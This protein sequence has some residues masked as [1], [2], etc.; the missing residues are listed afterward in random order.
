LLA[1]ETDPGCY[2]EPVRWLPELVRWACGKTGNFILDRPA[3]PPYLHLGWDQLLEVK[4]AWLRARPLLAQRDRL[5]R[6]YEQDP[7]RLTLLADVLM[8]G[9]NHDYLDW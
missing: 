8:D 2:P 6:W 9:K 3:S 7:A 4:T 1:I 5:M